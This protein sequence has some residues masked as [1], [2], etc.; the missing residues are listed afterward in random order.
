MATPGEHHQWMD[1]MKG[2]W[3]TENKF[4]QGPGDPMTS[5]GKMETRWFLD[6]HYLRSEYLGEMMGT[7][8]TGELTMAYRNAT[9]EYQVIWIDSGATGA[10]MAVGKREGDVITM[11]STEYT[12][13]GEFPTRNMITKVSDDEYLYEVYWNM[14]NIGEFKVIEIRYKRA[15]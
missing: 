1:F 6:K 8:F 7:P 10:M 12:P 15:K 4:W 14:P 11:T 3:T 2:S 13:M 5:T 9:D